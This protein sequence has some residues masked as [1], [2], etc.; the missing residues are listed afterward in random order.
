MTEEILTIIMV[1]VDGVEIDGMM[2][3]MTTIEVHVETLGMIEETGEI[4]IETEIDSEEIGTDL[5]TDTEDQITGITETE[6]E[7]MVMMTDT[8]MEVT[9]IITMIETAMDLMIDI[10]DQQ[11]S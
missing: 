3:M 2:T 11:K 10:T 5:T 6:T 4:G 7:V 9:E 8:D 1:A